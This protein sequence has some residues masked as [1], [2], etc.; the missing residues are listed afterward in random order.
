VVLCAQ[1]V[2]QPRTLPQLDSDG[3]IHHH[4]AIVS[5]SDAGSRGYERLHA[6]SN[7]SRPLP[8]GC[9]LGLGLPFGPS[10][11]SQQTRGCA[12]G[13]DPQTAGHGHDC[14]SLPFSIMLFA[15]KR[16][17]TTLP[18]WFSSCRWRGREK[19]GKGG[20]QKEDE[21]HLQACNQLS[22]CV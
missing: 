12:H 16:S 14:L 4:D 2:L 22:L 5:Q 18:H 7:S 19:G 13:T 10:R 3:T 15:S 21:R 6:S 9:R 20:G 8:L 11:S 1:R 17:L